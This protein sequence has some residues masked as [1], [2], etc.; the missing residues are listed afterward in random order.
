M[1]WLL[2]GERVVSSQEKTGNRDLDFYFIICE[3]KK[4]NVRFKL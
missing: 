2:S 4:R 1:L 3:E